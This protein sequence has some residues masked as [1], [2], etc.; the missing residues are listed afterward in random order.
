MMTNA[1][2]AA[3]AAEVIDR[4]SVIVEFWNEGLTDGQ[5]D[6]SLAGVS[7]EEA[8]RQIAIWMK[9]LPGNSW[10]TFLPNI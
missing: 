2:K 4:V 8:A 5:I 3:L 10:S 7:A 6:E 1:Q 9:S